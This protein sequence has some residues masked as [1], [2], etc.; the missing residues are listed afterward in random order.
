MLARALHPVRASG[1]STQQQTHAD[2]S[3]G[4]A[5]APLTARRGLHSGL[6]RGRGD[7]QHRLRAPP[8]GAAAGWSYDNR[9][10]SNPDWSSSGVYADPRA[11]PRPTDEGPST[12]YDQESDAL[13]EIARAAV[14]TVAGF[15]SFLVGRL[16]DAFLALLPSNV[17]RRA[18]ENTVKGALVLLGLALLQ[19]VLSL[20]LTVGTLVLAVYAAHAVFGMHLPL[21]PGTMPP[22]GGTEG[23]G[24]SASGA[25]PRGPTMDPRYG[26]GQF[27]YGD[28]P[29]PAQGMPPN[30]GGYGARPSYPQQPYQQPPYQQQQ[31]YQ[32]SPYQ[33]GPYPGAGQYPPRP[34]YRQSGPN[35]RPGPTIDV[36]FDN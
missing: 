10:P 12:S 7:A 3:Y 2:I 5:A 26:T 9:Q 32:Q 21:V 13:S 18:V 20:V 4:R 19:S 34:G 28:M 6:P 15:L 24:A 8:C 11:S 30:N 29:P 23:Y 36:Y 31:P 14:D 25:P 1:S 33:Q 17:K 27:G 16:S 35:Q 22:G